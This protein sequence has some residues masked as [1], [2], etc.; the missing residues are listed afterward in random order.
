MTTGWKIISIF[1]P[2]RKDN[3]MENNKPH[4]C[5]GH[6][7]RSNTKDDDSKV[8]FLK[9]E[10]DKLS[11]SNKILLFQKIMEAIDYKDTEWI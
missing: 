5:Q 11:Y 7:K 9:K 3:I 1:I 2:N 6:C 10:I 4:K 8:E